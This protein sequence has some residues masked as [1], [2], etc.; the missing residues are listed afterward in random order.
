MHTGPHPLLWYC[1]FAYPHWSCMVARSPEL[2]SVRSLSR[3]WGRP[4]LAARAGP[5]D[6][7]CAFSSQH[8]CGEPSMPRLRR[9]RRACAGSGARP[10]PEAVGHARFAP[11]LERPAPAGGV[12]PQC[13]R[14]A[15]GPRGRWGV[16]NFPGLRVHAG[17]LRGPHGRPC[18]ATAARERRPRLGLTR[19]RGGENRTS[20]C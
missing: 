4:S 16:P 7:P 8:C 6:A 12:D 2:C 3:R 1:S 15:A 13:T 14:P 18:V 17:A 10:R 5:S 19:M 20:M 11:A 9:P